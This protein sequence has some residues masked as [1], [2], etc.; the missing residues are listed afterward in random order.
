MH[1]LIQLSLLSALLILGGCQMTSLET[2]KGNGAV[3]IPVVLS[4]STPEKQFGCESIE[5][6][7]VEESK[8]IPIEAKYFEKTTYL[9]YALINDLAP[10]DYSAKEIRCYQDAEQ[11]LTNGDKFLVI[12]EELNFSVKSNEVLV[13][14]KALHGMIV[15]KDYSYSFGVKFALDLPRIY[16]EEIWKRFNAEE[17]LEG[18]T[19]S[20]Q[21]GAYLSLAN[22]LKIKVINWLS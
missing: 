6:M 4:I 14:E 2:A 18:W 10:G 9:G 22:S 20:K 12:E 7:F 11:R 5:I 17:N 8:R 3:L 16:A 13:S 1:K 19:I 15:D 21:K